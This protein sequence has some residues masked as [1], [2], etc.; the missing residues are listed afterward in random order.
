MF[1]PENSTKPRQ[2]KQVAFTLVELLVV[3]AIVAILAAILFPVFSQVREKARQTSCLSNSKQLSLG[4][5]MYVEDYDE[6]LPPD[7]DDAFVLWPDLLN[8]YVKS[9]QV[10]I[11]PSDTVKESNSYGLNQSIFIDDT[12][13]LPSPP[14]SAATL[15]ML[16]TPTATLLLGEVGSK[17]DLQTPKPNSFKMVAPDDDEDD[18][19][20]SRPIARHIG[21]VNLGFFDGHSKAMRLDQFYGNS[22]GVGMSFVANQNPVDLWFCA[23]PDNPG[24]C[25]ISH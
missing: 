12:D 11:C 4:V 18:P 15:A 6:T 17:N 14:P 20:E 3:I 24:A 9:S 13:F 16:D 22:T 1:K 25:H 5:L 8:P 10:R 23:Q 19:T 7:Q 21:R 2:N